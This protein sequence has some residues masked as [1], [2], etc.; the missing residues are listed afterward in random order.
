[1]DQIRNFFTTTSSAKLAAAISR[2]ERAFN[3]VLE[4]QLWWLGGTVPSLSPQEVDALLAELHE[5]LAL[6]EARCLG[7]LEQLK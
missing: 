6:L 2:A 1:M 3:A 4:L 7:K 5:Q